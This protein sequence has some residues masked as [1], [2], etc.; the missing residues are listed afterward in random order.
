MGTQKSVEDQHVKH[1]LNAHIELYTPPFKKPYTFKFCSTFK[2]SPSLKDTLMSSFTHL[3]LTEEEKRYLTH[4]H[5]QE[6]YLY[7]NVCPR[8]LEIFSQDII[9]HINNC[10]LNK[11][12]VKIKASTYG[13]FVCLM[14]ILSGDIDP[15]IEIECEFD[16]APLALL[17]KQS[18]QKALKIKNSLSIVFKAPTNSWLKNFTNITH[19][20]ELNCPVQYDFDDKFDYPSLRQVA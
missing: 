4:K 12:K 18:G 2:G 14:A 1:R 5:R 9:E 17:P 3:K 16:I 15:A 19:L 7:Q 20:S 6:L 11:N 8:E 13:T 10:Q